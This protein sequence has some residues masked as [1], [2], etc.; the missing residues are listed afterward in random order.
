MVFCFSLRHF[1]LTKRISS[2]NQSQTV[3]REKLRKALLYKKGAHKM[4]SKLLPDVVRS[5]IR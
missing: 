2:K 5:R 4:L 1:A 3:I